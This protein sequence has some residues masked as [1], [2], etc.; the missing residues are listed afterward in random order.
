[1]NSVGDIKA[2]PRDF[3][4]LLVPFLEWDQ[5]LNN[6]LSYTKYNIKSGPHEQILG[7]FSFVNQWAIKLAQC[8]MS[9]SF[10]IFPAHDGK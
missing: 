3:Y 4:S 5:L 2:N 9:A 6:N 10:S 7:R 8:Q 1:M